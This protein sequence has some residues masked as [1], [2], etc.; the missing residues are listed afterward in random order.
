[1]E[2]RT[3]WLF[4]W[5]AITLAVA[6]ARKIAFMRNEASDPLEDLGRAP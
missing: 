5:A 2:T 6:A 4:L 1:M 3:R